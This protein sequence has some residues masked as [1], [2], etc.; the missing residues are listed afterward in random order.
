MKRKNLLSIVA[1]LVSMG[2]GIQTAS[3]Q[4]VLQ[5]EEEPDQWRST[6]FV[7]LWAISMD[8]TAGIRGNEV[9]IDSSFSDLLEVLDAAISARFESHKG[10]WGYFLDGMYTKLNPKE[11]TPNGEV[12][13]DVKNF[14]GEAGGVY[15]FNRTVQG[16]FGLRYQDMSVDL[17]LPR[18][19]VGGDQNWLDGFIGIRLVPVRTDKWYVWLRGDVGGG[20]SDTVWNAVVGAGYR[21][22]NRWTLGGAYRVLSNDF[23]QDGFKWDV[24]YSG[25][26]IT[27]GYT[28]Q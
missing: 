24:D 2:L 9:E 1:L 4:G 16:I 15:H 26:G 28:F 6:L 7:Y 18:R 19:T 14:I 27:L 8:G 22:N 20:D 12:S 13:L 17:N 21:F 5:D 23:E 3:A 11:N 25:L 10:R